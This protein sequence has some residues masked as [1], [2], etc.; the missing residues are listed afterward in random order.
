METHGKG[1]ATRSLPKPSALVNHGPVR[2]NALIDGGAPGGVLGCL[3]Y[4]A[5]LDMWR[6]EW[7][8]DS[9]I[10]VNHPT[11]WSIL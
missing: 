6:I 11:V 5:Q 3:V 1:E 4:Q 10:N 7:T 2:T 9:S 8:I